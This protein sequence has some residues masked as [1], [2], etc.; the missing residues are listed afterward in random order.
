MNGV[1]TGWAAAQGIGALLAAG[2]SLLILW[3][4]R[5]DINDARKERRR[6]QPMRVLLNT[7]QEWTPVD[8]GYEYIGPSLVSIINTSDRPVRL[9]EVQAVG[10]SYPSKDDPDWLPW[11]LKHEWVDFDSQEAM[12]GPGEERSL[13]LPH[14]CRAEMHVGGDFVIVTIRDA[15]S[16]RWRRRTDTLDLEEVYGLPT[17]G[18]ESRRAMWLWLTRRLPLL[19]RWIRE[20]AHRSV[21][22]NPSRL[23]SSV[24]A[25]RWMQ[26][27][28]IDDSGGGQDPWLMKEGE[29]EVHRYLGLFMPDPWS[30]PQVRQKWRDDFDSDEPPPQVHRSKPLPPDG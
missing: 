27:D 17:R 5:R 4:Q 23:P 24:R 16:R 26:G 28:W 6:D 21:K 8:G 19:S 29:P 12:I 11:L 25:V 9:D 18:A 1:A 14:W 2:V 10:N 13:T 15:H 30:P 3:L 22:R 20:S 7:S